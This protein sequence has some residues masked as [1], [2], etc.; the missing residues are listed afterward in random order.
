MLSLEQHTH[1]IEPEEIPPLEAASAICHL[2]DRHPTG[3]RRADQRADAGACDYGRHDP[4]LVQRAK[5]ADV[6]EALKTTTAKNE[7]DLV[8]FA[9][10]PYRRQARYPWLWGHAKE[11]FREL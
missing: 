5:Y 8:S 11:T 10:R 9:A 1:S 3:E 4:H 7:R 6:G 2:I